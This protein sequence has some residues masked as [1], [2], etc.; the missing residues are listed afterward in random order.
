MATTSAAETPR[1]AQILSRGTDCRRL[2]VLFEHAYVCPV[3]L[4]RER[5]L[6]LS[7]SSGLMRLPQVTSQ[8][9]PS[10]SYHKVGTNLSVCCQHSYDEY[11]LRA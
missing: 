7:Q 9:S 10:R 6:L 1:A 4:G 5:Q 2:L 3:E 8:Q 11:S